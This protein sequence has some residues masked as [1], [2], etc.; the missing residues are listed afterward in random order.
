MKR[1]LAHLLAAGFVALAI[2]ASAS[3]SGGVSLV[4]AGN[5]V[6]PHRSFILTLPQRASI[7]T[8][9]VQVTENGQPVAHLTVKPTGAAGSA[10]GTVLLIDASN[11]M[12][13]R[14]ITSAMAAARTFVNRRNVGQQV[15]LITFNSS[16]NIVLPF[17]SDRGEIAAALAK[18]PQLAE[19]THIY[20]AVDEAVGL[21]D[22][23]GLRAGTVIL[24]SDGADVGS[25]KHFADVRQELVAAHVRLFSVGLKS[26]AFD[27]STLQRLA[28]AGK[29]SFSVAASTGDLARI[30]DRLGFQLANEYLVDYV[31]PAPPDKTV[32]VEARVAS[33]GSAVAGYRTPPLQIAAKPPLKPSVVDKVLQSSVTMFVIAA[34]VALLIYATLRAI[35]GGPTSSVRQRLGE[36]VSVTREDEKRRQEEVRAALRRETGGMQQFAFY[37]RLAEDAALADI[38]TPPARLAIF[39]LAGALMF[40]AIGY[41]ILGA[42]GVLAAV[43]PPL[44]LRTYVSRRLAR[45]RRRFA[46]QLADNLEVLASALRAGHSLVGAL[47]VVVDDAIEPSKSEFQRVLADEQLGVPLENALG[48]TVKRMASRDL[49][50]VAVVAVLQRDAGAN[51]AEVLDQIVENIRARQEIRRLV[52]VLTAQGRLARW[53]VSILPVAL[54]LIISLL[55]P[56]YMHPMWHEAIGHVALVACAILITVGS[57]IIGKIVNIDV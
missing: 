35:I 39:A 51:S 53:I 34:I 3:A 16:A 52:R 6:F 43:V 22:R 10:V 11:S 18:T 55:N 37:R 47:A 25:D 42:L 33:F 38:E 4:E 5:S 36:F 1:S 32:K 44:L 31:S 40:A 17:T 13:G 2:A 30:Y 29:G 19:G 56:S 14:P 46:D 7:A 23:A 15:A 9:D 12:A 54:L 41:A 26:G 57:I 45:K 21:I 48:I 24:L 50:Q 27:P 49:D 28:G 8:A 20:D